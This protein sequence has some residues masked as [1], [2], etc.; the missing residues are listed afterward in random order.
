MDASRPEAKGRGFRRNVCPELAYSP[1][2]PCHHGRGGVPFTIVMPIRSVLR[3]SLVWAVALLQLAVP[4]G[5]AVGDAQLARA[6]ANSEQVHVEDTGRQHAAP[7][8]P[9]SCVLCQFLGLQVAERRDAAVVLA[10]ARIGGQLRSTDWQ[11]ERARLGAQPASRAPQAASGSGRVTRPTDKAHA[12]QGARSGTR[13]R[14][15]TLMTPAG[16]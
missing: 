7:V 10:P 13:P 14:R 11:V 5:V 1:Q 3:R 2:S 4:P 6:A 16:D 8:H 15:T 9:D 12:V